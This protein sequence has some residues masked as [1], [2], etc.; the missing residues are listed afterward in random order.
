M[1]KDSL[2]HLNGMATASGHVLT[3]FLALVVAELDPTTQPDI[4]LGL[5]RVLAPRPQR[6]RSRYCSSV[7]TAVVVLSVST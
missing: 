7:L 5:R 2:A 3:A 1:S 6:F 4:Q